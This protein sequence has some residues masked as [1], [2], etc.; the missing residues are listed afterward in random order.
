MGRIVCITLLFTMM[1]W[2]LNG[3]DTIMFSVGL[4]PVYAIIHN[5]DTAFLSTIEEVNVFPDRE[6]KNKRDMRRYR[7]LIYNVKRVYPYAKLAG[8]KFRVIDST[9]ATLKTERQQREYINGVEAEIKDRYE[10]ELKKLTITQGRILIKLIDRETGHTSYELV[11]QLQGNF[12]AFLWQT[13]ARLFGSNLKWTFD[14]EG[15]DILVNEIVIMIEK[16]ML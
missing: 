12:R 5:G 7:K 4:V 9:M 16:G 10:E 3:Q 1:V 13:L 2:E 15:E 14:A 11:Q 8:E 6:F